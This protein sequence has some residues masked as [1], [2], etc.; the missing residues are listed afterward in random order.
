MQESFNPIGGPKA[1][2]D[3]YVNSHFPEP[4]IEIDENKSTET[5]VKG[6]VA[7]YMNRN[8]LDDYID[9]E[10]KLMTS[11]AF[12]VLEETL[13]E[14]SRKYLSDLYNTFDVIIGPQK[15]FQSTV[16]EVIRYPFVVNLSE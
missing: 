12:G 13:I 11:V 9:A 1:T 2:F 15:F 6:F 8:D 3:L 16:E 10:G 4:V 5:L 7:F 14:A